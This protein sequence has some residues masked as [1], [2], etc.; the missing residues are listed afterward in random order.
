MKANHQQRTPNANMTNQPI[1]ILID[2]DIGDDV[3]DALALA[4]ALRAP[5]VAL[6]GITTVFRD[7]P[8]RAILAGELLRVWNRE[9]VPVVAGCS[10]PFVPAWDSLHE[11]RALGRQFDAL[12]PALTWE[13]TLHA[14]TFIIEQVRAHHARGEMLT[15]VPIGALTNIALAF[16]LAPDIVSQCRVVMM[17]GKWSDDFPEWNILCDPEAA[18]MVFNSGAQIHMIGLDVTL[19]CVLDDA[20]IQMFRDSEKTSVRWLG[21]LIDLW[22]HPV[23]LHD[24]LTILSLFTELVKFEPKCLTVGLNEKE[25]RARTRPTDGQPNVQAAVSVSSEAAAALFIERIMS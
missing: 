15:L 7:A 1:P 8:R 25:V 24:P 17:G 5:E 16:Q 3:D 19:Q 20:Q 22:N 4:L 6:I 14:T 18:A 11:G 23:V 12:D 21:Q 9:D 2:T 13:D 10:E